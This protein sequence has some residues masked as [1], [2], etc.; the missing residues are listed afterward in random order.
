MQIF[1]VV[2]M[3]ECNVVCDASYSNHFSQRLLHGQHSLGPAGFDIC[4]ELMVISAANQIPYRAVSEHDLD[5]GITRGPSCRGMSRCEMTARRASESC[6]L[7][8]D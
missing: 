3:I 1:G 7:I 4:T 5:G 6:C 8:C 2:G